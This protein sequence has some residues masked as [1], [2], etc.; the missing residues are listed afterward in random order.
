[1]NDIISGRLT[2]REASQKYP[3]L[4]KSTLHRLVHWRLQN[5]VE[6]EAGGAP[7]K[8]EPAAV[9]EPEALTHRIREL[10]LALEK[11]N[12]KVAGLE[13]MIDIAQEQLGINIR[14]KSGTKR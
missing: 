9:A 13:T 7:P 4:S 11:S 2:Y 10:E 14:K 5:P 1:M 8:E 12:L 6:E 3:E